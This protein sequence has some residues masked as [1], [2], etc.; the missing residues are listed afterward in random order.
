MPGK[1]YII[2]GKAA[3]ARRITQKANSPAG[4]GLQCQRNGFGF[5]ARPAN[6]A[7]YLSLVSL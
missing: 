6:Q 4:A 2:E 7:A 3:G 1:P 5:G